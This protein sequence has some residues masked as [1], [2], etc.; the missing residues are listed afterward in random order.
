MTWIDYTILAVIGIS[1]IFS[2]ARG[3]V[4]EVLALVSWVVAF[5]VA[6]IFALD[7]ASI[8]SQML[9]DKAP[10]LLIAFLAVFVLTL[11][12]MSLI[13]IAISSVIKVA[14]LGWLDRILGA[15]F[16]LVRGGAIIVIGI[17][18]S[19]LTTLPHEP[20]W[21]NSMSGARLTELGDTAKAWLPNDLAKHI[22]YD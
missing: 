7:I 3:A 20:A 16:G 19:G 8:L 5:F 21:K 13:S 15:V 2:A 10:R 22:H 1:V 9:P 12:T 14:G 18:L 11:L 17:L 6:R 4:R